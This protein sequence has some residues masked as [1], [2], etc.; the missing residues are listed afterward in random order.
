MK[1]TEFENLLCVAGAISPE[2]EFVVFGSQALLGYIENPPKELLISMELD[3]YPKNHPEIARLIDA[4]LGRSSAFAKEHAYYAD[5]VTPELATWP[6]GWTERLIRFETSGVTAWCAELHDIVVSKLA[7]GRPRD[8]AYI[9]DLLRH[10]LLNEQTL[11]ERI[12]FLSSKADRTRLST[13]FERLLKQFRRAKKPA[14]AKLK[15]RKL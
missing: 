2:K 9:Q 8:V 5:T 3:L 11:R 6:D 13:A 4:R 14:K 15:R 12:G 1:R 10:K 7:A